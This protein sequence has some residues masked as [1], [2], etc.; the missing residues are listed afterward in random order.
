M[1][2]QAKKA[3][4]RRVKTEFE[5]ESLTEQSHKESCD[6]HNIMRKYEKTG[7]VNHLAQFK[8]QYMDMS[9]SVEFHQA[10]LIVA[11]ANSMWETVP[12]KIRAVFDNNPGKFVDFM[13]SE[14][15]REAILEMGLDASHLPEPAEEP[16]PIPVTVI[17]DNPPVD[18]PPPQ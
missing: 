2:L 18:E 9:N 3:L 12:S 10:Q 8:G 6:I 7:I 15:N 16:Q 4:R 1:S 11:E 5:G 13:Q 17:T 14:N